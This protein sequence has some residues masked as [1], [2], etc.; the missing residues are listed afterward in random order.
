MAA[1]VKVVKQKL[2]SL[3]LDG[4]LSST[5]NRMLGGGGYDLKI[6]VPK[7]L[8][9]KEELDKITKILF[10]FVESPTALAFK[11]DFESEYTKIRDFIKQ[12]QDEFNKVEVPDLIKIELLDSNLLM[13]AIQKNQPLTSEFKLYKDFMDYYPTFLKCSPVN[14]ILVFLK[15]MLPHKLYLLKNETKSTTTTT[16]TTTTSTSDITDQMKNMKIKPVIGNPNTAKPQKVT[17]NA[18]E[19]IKN[20]TNMYESI[21]LPGFCPFTFA[22]KLDLS[23][24]YRNGDELIRRYLC[25]FTSIVFDSAYRMYKALKVPDINVEDFIQIIESQLGTLK[26]KIPRCD[27]AFDKIASSMNLFRDNFETYYGDFIK[28]DNKTI[29]VENFVMDVAKN[30]GDTSAD[31]V[32]QFRQ[33]IKFYKDQTQTMRGKIPLLDTAIDTVNAN[34]DQLTSS[35]NKDD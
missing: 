30:C 29:I 3:G 23:F 31:M 9:I 8:N 28:S 11:A 24:I 25:I 35:F 6:I 1:K 13:E 27:K 34:L 21:E 17:F 20:I 7:Y 4:N 12:T 18:E 2:G 5:M 22:P 26:A 10:K 14:F 16:T 19:A 32:R 15:N 33:I